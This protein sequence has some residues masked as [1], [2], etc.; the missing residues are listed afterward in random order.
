MAKRDEVTQAAEAAETTGGVH[1]TNRWLLAAAGLLVAVGVC[2]WI[3]VTYAPRALGFGD[4]ISL[5]VALSLRGLGFLMFLAAA[6]LMIRGRRA[7]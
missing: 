7:K 4:E 2:L 3:A 1:A 6:M 5:V